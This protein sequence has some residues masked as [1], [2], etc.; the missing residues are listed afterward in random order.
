MQPTLH[1]IPLTAILTGALPRDRSQIEPEALA[2]L[3]GSIATTGLRQPIEVWRLSTPDGPFEYGLISGLRRLTAHHNLAALRNNGDFTTIAAF[4]RTPASIPHALA[5]MIEENEARAD[6]SPW[7]KGRILIEC[8]S[9]GH[10]DTI[11]QALKALH[12]NASATQR[13]RIRALAN[14]VDTMEGILMRPETFSLRQLLRLNSALRP[15]FTPVIITA[16]Q[17]HH[18]KSPGAQW[19]LLLPILDEAESALR[20][21]VPYFDPRPGRPRR[22]LKPRSGLTVRRERTH[23]G[24][25]LHFTGPEAEG[26]M[27]ESVMDAI[28]R[29]YGPPG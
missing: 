15:D 9:E 5:L 4:I 2:E 25:T 7:E 21:P 19:S 10:F 1:T 13:H 22:V 18:E 14:V 26:M 23:D 17:E 24:W 6:L 11:D 29:L 3:Q 16:L 8:V 27:M 28:E 20:D 12:P